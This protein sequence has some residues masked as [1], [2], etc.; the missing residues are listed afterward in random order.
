[1]VD[2]IAVNAV[3]GE[4]SYWE[5]SIYMGILEGRFLCTPFRWL[6]RWGC[7]LSKGGSFP[8][9]RERSENASAHCRRVPRKGSIFCRRDEDIGFNVCPE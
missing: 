1:M 9:W 2:K 8:A 6:N 4:R 5:Y 7:M 3:R